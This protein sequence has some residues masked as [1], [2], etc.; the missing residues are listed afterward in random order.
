MSA[1]DNNKKEIIEEEGLIDNNSLIEEEYK[2]ASLN[3]I[4]LAHDKSLK[5]VEGTVVYIPQWNTNLFIAKLTVKEMQE[6][7]ELSI[8]PKTDEADRMDLIIRFIMLSVRYNDNKKKQMF[9]YETHKT[10]IE[11]LEQASF[12]PL[13]DAILKI[14]GLGTQTDESIHRIIASIKRA[15]K[16]KDNKTRNKNLNSALDKLK[17]LLSNNQTGYIKNK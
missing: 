2:F 10:M 7:G 17:N 14:N 8:D 3:D 15:K 12:N 4:Q 16:S 5:K 11:E 9:N 1:E 6:A 13:R